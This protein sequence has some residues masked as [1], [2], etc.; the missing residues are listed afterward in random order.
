MKL[1]SIMKFI[2]YK[3]TSHFDRNL[4]LNILNNTIRYCL[5]SYQFL[6]KNHGHIFPMFCHEQTFFE[7]IF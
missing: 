3:K 4:L 2:F 7:E 5:I 1:K 6:K